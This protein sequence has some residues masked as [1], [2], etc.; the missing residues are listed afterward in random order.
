MVTNHLTVFSGNGCAGCVAVIQ[1]FER[2]G[3]AHKVV[4]ID[5]DESGM[6]AFKT[7]GHRTVPQVYTPDLEYLGGSLMDI[8]KLP[9]GTLD[10]FK[11]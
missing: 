5:E 4:K 8:L 2:L 10:I 1:H 7:L 9:K 11:Q 3:I 6:H